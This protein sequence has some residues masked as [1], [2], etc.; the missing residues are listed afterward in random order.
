MRLGQLLPA[1]DGD[2]HAVLGVVVRWD[3]AMASAGASW[4]G[5][6]TGDDLP[7]RDVAQLDAP[8]REFGAD[9]VGG[10]ALGIA[11]A[12]QRLLLVGTGTSLRSAS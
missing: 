9:L 10:H 5:A 2:D 4:R 3:L 7:N 12:P 8:A 6:P 1:A 11:D